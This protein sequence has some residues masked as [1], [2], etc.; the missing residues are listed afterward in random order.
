M[1]QNDQADLDLVER[2]KSGDTSAFR[3]IYV[4]YVD[5]LFLFGMN[6]IKEEE[7]CTDT[8]QDVFVWL[9]ENHEELTI[10]HLKS[11][12]YAAVKY[13]LTRK[14]LTSRRREEILNHRAAIIDVVEDESLALKELQAVI[15]D[16]IRTLPPKAREVFVLSREDYLPHHDIAEQL[17][18]SE[19]TVRNH[20]AVSLRKLRVYL[21]KNFYW[22]FFLFFFH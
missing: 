15:H 6:I 13:K 20:L 21:S 19:N 11:Y 18:I 17:G 16:F 1:N 14:I 8:I 7:D 3:T 2:L 5:K 4:K 22:T 12:L 9:W 10:S